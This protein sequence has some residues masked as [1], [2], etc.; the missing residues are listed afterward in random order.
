MTTEEI[1][2]AISHKDKKFPREALEQAIAQKD[3]I[4]PHLL[5]ILERVADDPDEVLDLENHSHY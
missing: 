2:K 3:E 4:T 5:K 1:L